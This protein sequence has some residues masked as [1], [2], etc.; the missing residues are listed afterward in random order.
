MGGV[1]ED[2]PLRH[3]LL[4]AVVQQRVDAPNHSGAETFVLE[5]GE[6]FALNSSG[7]LE[8]VVKPLDL[9][10][11]QLVQW[12]A[13]NSGDD[14]VLDVV[15]VV[16]FGV[17]PDAGL[18]VDLIPHFHPRTDR[19]SPGFG[20]VQPLAFADRGFEFLFHFGLRFTQYVLDDPFS[21]LRVIA[22]RVPALPASVLSLSDVPFPVCSSFWHGISPFRQRT[23]P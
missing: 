17:G 23:I 11:G 13:P 1:G 10:G 12:D 21:A 16:G 20:Y 14:M 2:Q 9:D 7:F 5:F 3:R 22:R 18:S 6:V 8:V 15:G 19:V 4:Q